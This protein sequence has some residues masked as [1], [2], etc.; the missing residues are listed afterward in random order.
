LSK[1]KYQIAIHQH[2]SLQKILVNLCEIKEKG[3]G[4][5]RNFKLSKSQIQRHG[6]NNSALAEVDNL[7]ILTEIGDL[8]Y[9]VL[10]L[11]WLFT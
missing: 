5:T 3:E 11:P 6:G 9:D 4:H 2:Q 8:L 1:L 7:R 10:L